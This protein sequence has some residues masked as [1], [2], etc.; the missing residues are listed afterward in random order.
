MT[1]AEYL[2]TEPAYIHGIFYPTG[3]TV[4]FSEDLPPAVTW[5]PQN[6]VAKRAVDRQNKVRANRGLKL[7]ELPTIEQL[8]ERLRVAGYKVSNPDEGKT[9]LSVDEGRDALGALVLDPTTGTP[10]V[11]KTK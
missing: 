6:D 9:T 5:I 11:K 7:D 8:L 4:S 3:T 2:L 1:A 10:D